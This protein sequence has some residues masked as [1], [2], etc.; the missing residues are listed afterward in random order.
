M[1]LVYLMKPECLVQQKL[2]CISDQFICCKKKKNR[3]KNFKNKLCE[4][5][6]IDVLSSCSHVITTVWLHH[7]DSDETPGEKAI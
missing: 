5:P 3:I 2:C 4:Y 7:L 1:I 6:L